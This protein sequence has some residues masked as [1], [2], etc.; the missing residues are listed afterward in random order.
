MSMS[1]RIYVVTFAFGRNFGSLL[2]A[3]GLNR[4]LESSGNKVSFIYRFQ[5]KNALLSHPSLMLARLYNRINRKRRK[6][7]FKPSDLAI[8]EA[9]ARRTRAYI[10]DNYDVVSI[11]TNSRWRQCVDE[12][13]VFIAGSDIIWQPYNGYPEK[14]FL[15]FAHYSG[16]TCFSYA[17]SFGSKSLPASYHR[18]YRKYLRAFKGVAV[19]EEAAAKM[20]EPIISRKVEKVVDPT[21]LLDQGDWDVYAA[22]ANLSIKAAHQQYMLCYFVMSDKRYWSYVEKVQTATGLQVVVLP[23]SRLDQSQ[24]Y[25]IAD[26]ATPYEFIWLIKHASLVLTDSFHACV[27]STIYEI[28]FY[29]LPRER[30]AENDKYD[31]FLSRYG[32]VDRKVTDEERFV[33]N[34]EIDWNIARQKIDEDR[35]FSKRY[36]QRMLEDEGQYVEH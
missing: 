25:T 20:L 35:A 4:Y 6:K 9:S 19:R 8:S 22:K 12:K 33:R 18:A 30:K 7:F 24:P 32:L 15:D 1:R 21:L 3:T 27:F 11:M 17:S 36:L 34:Q 23:M 29:L 2:Q 16:L 14:Y 5:A 28:E 10:E 13:A 31:D 26:D